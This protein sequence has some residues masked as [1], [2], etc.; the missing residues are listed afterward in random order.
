[1]RKTIAVLATLTIVLGGFA[2]AL[3]VQ[4]PSVATA[5]ETDTSES[6]ASTGIEEILSDLVEE[7]V[8]SE[9]QADQILAALQQRLGEFRMGHRGFGGS[10][11]ATAAE[12]IGI[13]IDTLREALR[14][15]QTLAEVAE[16]NGVSTQ[17]L[18]DGLV[19][20][21]NA[22]L[23]EAI[24]DGKLT[25]EQAEEIRANAAERIESMVNGE[26]EGRFGAHR[27]HGPRGFGPG[28]IPEDS[29]DAT[30]TSA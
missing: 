30:G 24:E 12:I 4:T 2:T 25:G 16:A 15:G 28:Q 10:H 5:Q 26:C 3:I 22:N 17:A 13:D 19:V 27:F 14:D 1:M 7:D 9:G 8:I 29:T 20:E 23:D 21:M 11:L 18:I 6:P